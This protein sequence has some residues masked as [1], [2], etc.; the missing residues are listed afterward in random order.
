[1]SQ[2]RIGLMGGTF[3]PIHIAHLF[4]AEEARIQFDLDTILFVPNGSPPHK[5]GRAVATAEQRLDMVR[6]AI[7]GNPAF[8]ASD[9]EI[10]ETG[11]AYAVDTL[12]IIQSMHAGSQVLYITGIDTAAELM[13]WKSPEKVMEMAEFIAVGRPGYSPQQLKLALPEKYLPKVHVLESIHL[14]ISST[15]IRERLSSGSTVRYL[16]PDAVL[17]YIEHNNLYR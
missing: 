7:H 4:I 17:E 16:V 11:K 1:M 14:D 10:R 12:R 6:L 2:H 15:R 3:D 8:V 9:I 5:A 13:T